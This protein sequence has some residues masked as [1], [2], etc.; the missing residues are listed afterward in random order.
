MNIRSNKGITLI[1]LMI[2]I[3]LS[4]LVMSL[5]SSVPLSG[6]NISNDM[7]RSIKA[8]NC[9]RLASMHITKYAPEAASNFRRVLDSPDIG[10][11]TLI[12]RAYASS[13][14]TDPSI[15]STYVFDSSED[16]ILYY[17]TSSS[18]PVIVSRDIQDCSFTI[19][20]PGLQV[21]ITG[22]DNNGGNG[23]V[24]DTFVVPTATSYPAIFLV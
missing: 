10:D 3:T 22:V 5:V 24:I 12:Y 18:S 14:E 4:L 13:T 17:P 2:G 8:D 7:V 6:N 21:V 16:M 20:G 11:V 9:A 23:C 19:I 15:I 1:E